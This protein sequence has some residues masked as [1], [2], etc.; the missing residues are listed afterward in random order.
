M[1]AVPTKKVRFKNGKFEGETMTINADSETARYV[2]ENVGAFEE[3][4][5]PQVAVPS[6]VRTQTSKGKGK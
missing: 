6:D 5:K 1:P 4:K 2:R 3:V